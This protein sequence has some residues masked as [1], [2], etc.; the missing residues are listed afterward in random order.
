[1]T[2]TAKHDRSS[3]KSA[4]STP[5]F[6]NARRFSPRTVSVALIV[7]KPWAS[8]AARTALV[9]RSKSRTDASQGRFTPAN[10]RRLLRRTWPHF[11][12][13]VPDLPTEPTLGSRQN[14]MLAALTL[15][16]FQALLDDGVERSYAVELVGDTCWVIYRQWGQIPKLASRLLTHDPVRAMRISVNMFL[17]FPFNR[18]GYRYDDRPEP[19]GRAL[20]MLRCPVADYLRAHDAADLAVGSW[21]NLDFQLA[22]LWGGT[23]ERHGSLAA[24]APLCDFRFRANIGK[25]P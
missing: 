5:V 3:N 24:G 17:H 2:A 25:A 6:P 10:T 13:L 16:M 8:W 9:G 15:A 21:C 22:H 1:M 11:Q 4:P 20:D 23:L 7:L 14:V 12:R 19:Q 18:P